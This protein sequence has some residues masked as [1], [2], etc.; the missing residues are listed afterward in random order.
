[1]VMT[2]RIRKPQPGSATIGTKTRNGISNAGKERIRLRAFKGKCQEPSLE[3]AKQ[4]RGVA[5]VL[6]NFLTSSIFARQFSKLWNDRSQKLEH[7]RGTDVRHDAE[8]KNRAVAERTTAEKIKHRSHTTSDFGI[9]NI[10]E[11]LT[12]DLRID[13]RCC[14]HSSQA[15]DHDHAKS[16]QCPSAQLRNFEGIGKCGNHRRKGEVMSNG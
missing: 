16:E 13:T 3:H 11:P 5:G 12:Q 2:V 10:E 15:H 14:H 9:S 6:R 1:M 4:N 8:R 7:D